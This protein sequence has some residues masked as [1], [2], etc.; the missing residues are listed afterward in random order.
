MT[1]QVSVVVHGCLTNPVL[2]GL[3][4]IQKKAMAQLVM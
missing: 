4:F 3:E 1:M 2:I